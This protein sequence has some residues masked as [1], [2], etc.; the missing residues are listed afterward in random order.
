MFYHVVSVNRDVSV[1]DVAWHRAVV[2]S[3]PR[4]A[5]QQR[6]STVAAAAARR[7]SRW[8]LQS[9]AGPTPAESRPFTGRRDSSDNVID[10]VIDDVIVVSIGG[11]S[12]ISN[13]RRG[14]GVQAWR[15]PDADRRRLRP[16]ITVSLLS[17]TAHVR[18]GGWSL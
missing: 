7:P 2:R 9:T 15:S 1:F 10:D 4:D 17:S 8:A 13:S 11:G 3:N 16:D 5:R 18:Q 14:Q 6:Q 12:S